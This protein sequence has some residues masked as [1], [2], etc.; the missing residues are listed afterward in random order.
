[1]SFTFSVASPAALA[2]ITSPCTENL[3]PNS[4]STPSGRAARAAA[5]WIDSAVDDAISTIA[6]CARAYASPTLSTAE[7]MRDVGSVPATGSAST[8]RSTSPT[9]TGMDR[10]ITTTSAHQPHRLAISFHAEN[11]SI[12]VRFW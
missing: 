7:S 8:S 6:S 11:I 9:R 1:V 5:F 4:I 3:S 10:R 2:T 12:P